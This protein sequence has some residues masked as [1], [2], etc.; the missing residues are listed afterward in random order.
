MAIQQML[1]GGGDLIAVVSATTTTLNASTLFGPKYS[2]SVS[3]RL[4][5]QSGVTVGSTNPSTPA[6][7]IPAGLSGQLIVENLGSIQ[8]AGGSAGAAGVGGTGGDAIYSQAAFRLINHAGATIYGGGGGGGRGGSGGTGGTG[9]YNYDCS[10]T[11]SLG[12]TPYGN[13]TFDCNAHCNNTFGG[14]AYCASSNNTP[15]CQVLNSGFTVVAIRCTDCRR[16]VSQSCTAYTSGGA[17]GAGGTGGVGR[18]YGQSLSTGSSGGGGGS[19]GTNAGW[20]GTGGSGGSGGDF[21]ASGVSGN[22]GGT[23]GNGNYSGGSAGAGGSSGGLAG[24]SLFG[25]STFINL[26]NNGTIAG[27]TN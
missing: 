10:Y 26:T 5:I 18:G 23:G 14:G 8:G 22:T 9:Y 17:G 4:I 7:L 27:R 16:Y 6:L 12:S 13:F 20:G 15:Y 25:L 21:G 11:Q 1:L 24:F 19:P 3:K 2:Q